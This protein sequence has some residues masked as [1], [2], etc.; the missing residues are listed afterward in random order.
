MAQEKRIDLFLRGHDQAS[1]VVRRTTGTVV[2]FTGA[3]KTATAALGTL[4]APFIALRGILEA[5]QVG[6]E[7]E[8]TMDRVQALTG[9]TGERLLQLERIAQRLGRTTIFSAS[10]SAEAMAF[11]ALAGFETG[12]IMK[13]ITPTLELAAAGQLEV[14]N[15]ADIVV[16]I[17]RGMGVE[18]ENVGDAVN[19]LTKAFTT[20][21]TDL[22]QLGDA[23]KFIGPV[24]RAAGRDLEE[25]V[26]AVQILSNAG[27]QA[28]LSGTALRNILLALARP[29]PEAQELLDKLGVSALDAAGNI[30]P[31][32]DI[33]DDFNRSLAGAGSG[34]KLAVF[35]NVFEKRAATAFSVLIEQGGA[36]LRTF[37]A[38]LTE[39][40]GTSERIASVMIDNLSGAW[41][42]FK[43]AMAGLAIDLTT[44][45]GSALRSTIEFSTRPVNTLSFLV[46]AMHQWATDVGEAIGFVGDLWGWLAGEAE[47]SAADQI[48]SLEVVRVWMENWGTSVQVSFLKMAVAV[49]ETWDMVRS[50]FATSIFNIGVMFQNMIANTNNLFGG[51]GQAITDTFTN[52]GIVVENLATNMVSLFSAA[53]EAIRTRSLDPFTNLTLA[54]LADGTKDVT[55]DLLKVVESLTEGTIPFKLQTGAITHSLREALGI[56][57]ADLEGGLIASFTRIFA[58]RAGSLGGDGKRPG[59]PKPELGPGD[60]FAAGS[61]PRKGVEAVLLSNQFLGLAAR[62]NSP[63][64]RLA[65]RTARA[66]E[67]IADTTRR[68]A[69]A[70]EQINQ[71]NQWNGAQY[72]G[73]PFGGSA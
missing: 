70:I 49:S 63:A 2:G 6:A 39:S 51:L 61:E 65:E 14:A 34:E 42:I 52:V 28:E 62:V 21:N 67:T 25:M 68:T 35:A 29:T 16:K 48:G 5:A 33:I 17:M 23:M 27:L 13:A 64:E 50:L 4:L 32:A 71:Q 47:R 30:R 9:E 69:Q 66:T 7:F 37:E 26:A 57:Q 60:G 12:E 38:R 3:V 24:A 72:P 8:K 54:S 19:V 43:S 41:T 58:E 46:R 36:S 45:F 55:D 31:L 15:S 56:A 1:G 59:A 73:L 10:Q 40:A 44:V 20:A 11:F 18:A 22:M 53:F